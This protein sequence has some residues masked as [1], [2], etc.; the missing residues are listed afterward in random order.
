M[1]DARVAGGTVRVGLM[2]VVLFRSG[3][4]DE[5]VSVFHGHSSLTMLLVVGGAPRPRF[6]RSCRDLIRTRQPKP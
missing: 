5:G 3:G 1:C 6:S 2:G 4:G